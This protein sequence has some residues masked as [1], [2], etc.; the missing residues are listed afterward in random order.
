M[1]QGNEDKEDIYRK[2]VGRIQI[3]ESDKDTKE[4]I[5]EN[6]LGVYARPYI[7]KKMHIAEVDED[8]YQRSRVKIQKVI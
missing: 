3:A 2:Y 4:L 6:N 7:E 8:F 5:D 1:Y